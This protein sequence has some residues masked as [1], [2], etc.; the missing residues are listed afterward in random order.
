MSMPPLIYRDYAIHVVHGS[1]DTRLAD[2]ISAFWLDN[3][4]M[5]DPIET[6]RRVADVVCVA[7]NAAGEIVGVNSVYLSALYQPSRLYYFYRIF[8]RKQDRVLGLSARMRKLCV[9]HL[10]AAGGDILGVAMVTENPKLMKPA[11]RR[12][13]ARAGWQYLGRGPLGRDVWTIEFAQSTPG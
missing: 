9:D 3:E 8:L 6:A 12:M 10:R 4:A 7:R 13:L 1:V 5:A 11:A 2:E